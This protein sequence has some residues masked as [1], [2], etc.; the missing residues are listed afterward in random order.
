MVVK[1]KKTSDAA[2]TADL[3]GVFKTDFGDEIGSFGGRKVNSERIPTGI[4]ELDYGLGG[5]LPRGKVSMIYGPESSGKT[6]CALLAIANHQKLFPDKVCSFVDIEHGFDPDWA[7]Q[8]GVNCK[9]LAVIKPAYAEQAID[10]IE[11]LLYAKDCGIVVVDSIAAL[12]TSS[13]LDASAE[14]ESMGGVAKTISKLT[15][16]TTRAL[17]EAEKAGRYPTLIYINQI[18]FK[19]GVVFGDPETYPGGTK[20]KH[21]CSIILRLYGKNITDSKVSET[22]PVLKE[23]TYVVKKWKCPIQSA[24]GKF[25]LAM[26]PYKGLKPGQS[27]DCGAVIEFLKSFG[28]FDK[29]QKGKGYIIAGEPYP[30]ITAFKERYYADDSFSLGVKHLVINIAK[31]GGVIEPAGDGL[32]KDEAPPA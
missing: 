5:G 6:N 16:K 11:S 21:Q 4:F 32:A 24:S 23:I 30:T 19:V 31:N 8:L 22:M 15:K 2:S 27:D 1:I 7:T 20:P 25:S 9:K 29:D 3:L 18:M 26:L 13:E 12:V 10:I 14:K 28:E 17:S